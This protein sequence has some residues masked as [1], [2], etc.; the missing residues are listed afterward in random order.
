MKT[1]TAVLAVAAYLAIAPGLLCAQQPK[2]ATSPS[3]AGIDQPKTD[4]AGKPRDSA[5]AATAVPVRIEGTGP[6]SSASNAPL[7][8]NPKGEQKPAQ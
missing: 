4:R 2:P 6:Q 5:R 1:I 7:K 8:F 3:D